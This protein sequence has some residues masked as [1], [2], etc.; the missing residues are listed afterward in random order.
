MPPDTGLPLPAL[1][2]FQVS[3]FRHPELL[4]HEFLFWLDRVRHAAGVAFKLTSDGRTP[5]HNAEVGGAPSSLHLRGR[6]VD[7]TVTPWTPEALARVLVAVCLTPTPQSVGWELE[8]VAGPQD[9]HVH[10]GLRAEPGLPNRCVLAL[11]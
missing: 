8:L 3:E 6:A 10:L 9:K 4:A 2:H 5:E 7:F 1:E 11:D